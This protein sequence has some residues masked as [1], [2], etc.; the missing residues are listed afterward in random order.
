MSHMAVSR[1]KMTDARATSPATTTSRTTRCCFA[2]SYGWPVVFSGWGNHY[3]PDLVLIPMSPRLTGFWALLILQ[4]AWLLGYTVSHGYLPA[5]ATS[6]STPKDTRWP[7]DEVIGPRRRRGPSGARGQCPHLRALSRAAIFLPGA[8]SR[9][10]LA[11]AP[12]AYG[13]RASA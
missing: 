5:F 6:T 13:V 9:P 3:V 2:A 7:L 12:R 11:D 4:V 1:L 8:I 10:L